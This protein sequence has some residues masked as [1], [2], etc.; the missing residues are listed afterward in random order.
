MI[1]M[2]FMIISL[3]GLFMLMAANR[4]HITISNVNV[5]MSNYV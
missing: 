5:P 1:V 3:N 2:F 4:K